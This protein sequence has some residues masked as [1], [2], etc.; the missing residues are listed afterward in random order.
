MAEL[1]HHPLSPSRDAERRGTAFPRS[2]WERELVL[3]FA[4]ALPSLCTHHARAD[5]WD[6]F[7]GPNGAGQS[8]AA[9][10]PAQWNAENFLWKRPLPGVG[11]SSPVVW[12]NR[13]FISS[14]DT[15]T[16]EQIVLAFDALNGD[17]HWERRF[18][19]GSYNLNGHN[20][21]ASSTPAVDDQHLYIMWLAGGR[22]TLAALTHDGD[23]VWRRDVGPFE[24]THGFGKSPIAVDGLVIVANDSE[25]QS[26]IVAFDA[27]SGDVRW[28]IS[29][30]SG[31][32]AFAT[33]CLLNPDAERKELLAT[34]T[35]AGLV[36]I[37]VA[38]GEIV[39]Q[40]FQDDLSQRCVS[41]PIVAGGLV[42][43]SCGQ[44]GNGKLLIAARPGSAHH[45]PQEA[46]R[47][48][49]SIPNVPTPVVAGDLLFLWHDR[50]VVSC[51]DVA[52]GRQHWRE[53]I[54]GDF[55]SSPVRIGDRIFC[56]SRDGEVVVLAADRKF[57]LL[58]RN[59]L[60]EPCHAT[61]AI[62]HNRLYLR[63]EATLHCIGKP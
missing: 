38:S 28:R 19:A 26:A 22:I 27:F 25:A 7:R 48:Q 51:H 9:G 18:D 53:R 17:L 56:A 12:D 16:G 44:G 46:Y 45:D 8:E 32:T 63:T 41:S 13:L 23:E 1:R 3:F 5:H 52:T 55:H 50:G 4:V 30:E 59:A 60:D 58:A 11:H 42:F 21:F 6:R 36:A 37:D 47:L 31:I 39:W 2:A 20:S 14:A 43:V 54:G 62:A 34:S 24:E 57:D 40:G 29:R 35:A 10:I 49:Q 33:P 15:Q 61:P